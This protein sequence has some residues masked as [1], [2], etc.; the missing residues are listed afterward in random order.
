MRVD[1]VTGNIWQALPGGQLT[2]RRSGVAQN[3]PAGHTMQCV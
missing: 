2:G 3:M 1:E